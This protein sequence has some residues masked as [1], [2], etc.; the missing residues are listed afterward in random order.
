MIDVCIVEAVDEED[1]E[2]KEAEENG[3]NNQ[4]EA[5]KTFKGRGKVAFVGVV[6]RCDQCLE[7]A[8][9]DQVIRAIFCALSS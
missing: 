5:P 2:K 9:R 7:M 3:E 6:A 4:K 8:P 1:G